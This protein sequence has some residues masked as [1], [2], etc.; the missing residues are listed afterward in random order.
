[1]SLIKLLWCKIVGHKPSEA[2]YSKEYDG[3]M[4]SYTTCKRCGIIIDHTT[5]YDFDGYPSDALI[6]VKTIDKDE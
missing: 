1:M 6:N 5:F 2:E 3:S 4:E